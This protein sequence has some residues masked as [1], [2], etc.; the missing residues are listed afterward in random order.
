V[1]PVAPL[2][3]NVLLTG[4]SGTGKSEIAR[5]LHASGPRAGKPMVE[6]NCAALP[7]TLVESELFGA[8]AGSHSTATAPMTGKLAAVENGTLLLDEIGELL[9]AAQSKLPQLLQTKQYYPLGASQPVTADVRPLSAPPPLFTRTR[10]GFN[11]SM[12]HLR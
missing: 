2:D 4:V 1:S 3:V 7:E 11:W 6:V 5:V 10:V 12:Q 9:H 8:L